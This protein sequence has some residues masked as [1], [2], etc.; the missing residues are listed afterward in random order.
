MSL[1]APR[2]QLIRLIDVRRSHPPA[3]NRPMSESH[4]NSLVKLFSKSK[5][6]DVHN[7]IICSVKDT[8]SFQKLQ[9]LSFFDFDVTC[10]VNDIMYAKLRFL[11]CLQNGN[12]RCAAWKKVWELQKPEERKVMPLWRAIIFDESELEESE[13]DLLKRNCGETSALIDGPD[14][15]I[16]NIIKSAQ[17]A[18]FNDIL[19]MR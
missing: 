18:G 17:T 19:K 14:V 13:L 6:D 9:D 3:D 1:L 8:E 7:T 11:T 2:R 16:K 4:L 5:P 15:V 12:H 10:L